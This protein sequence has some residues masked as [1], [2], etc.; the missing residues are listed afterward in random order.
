MAPSTASSSRRSRPDVGGAFPAYGANHG[1]TGTV[2]LPSG[3]H[4]VC[5]YV[6]NLGWGGNQLISCRN[7]NVP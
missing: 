3:A 7:V 4:Q 5:V 2:P 1:F 6:I